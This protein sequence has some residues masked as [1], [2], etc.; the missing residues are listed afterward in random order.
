MF[1]NRGNYTKVYHMENKSEA[2]NALGRFVNDVGVPQQILTDNAKEL[3]FGEW[4]KMC[5]KYYIIQQFTEPHSPWQNPAELAIGITKRML[6]KLMKKTNTPV[7]L[8]DYCWSY[9]SCITNYAMFGEYPCT[10]SNGVLPSNQTLL[11]A[12]NVL[13]S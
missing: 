13:N 8:W 12:V 10:F 9:H 7:R 2:P 6:C 4:K 11:L 1:A 5:N 3:K